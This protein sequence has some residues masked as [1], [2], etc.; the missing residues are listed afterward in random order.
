MIS[1]RVTLEQVADMPLGEIAALPA[2]Q[3]AHL[4]EEAANTLAHAKRLKDHIDGALTLKY[5]DRAAALRAAEGKDSGTVRFDDCDVVVTV[6]LPKRIDWDQRQLAAVVER[7]RAEGEDPGEYVD[8]AYRVPE[9]KY[10]AWPAHIRAVFEPA[11]TVRFGKPAVRLAL[12]E[13]EAG[14]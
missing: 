11:R 9:R 12:A 1:N 14:R 13:R 7:I 10:A 8:V 2:E 6:E 5:G 4:V 3:L